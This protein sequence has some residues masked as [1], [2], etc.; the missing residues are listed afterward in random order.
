MANRSHDERLLV[1]LMN[2]VVLG[3]IYQDRSKSVRLRYDGDYLQRPDAVPLS[4]SM[5][6]TAQRHNPAVVDPWLHNLLPGRPDVLASWRRQ[7]GVADQSAF[8]LLRHVG[9]DVAGAAQFVRPER[10]DHASHP[11]PIHPLGDEDIAEWLRRLSRDAAAWEPT[12]GAGR[13]SLAGAQAKFALH[14]DSGQWGVPSGRTPT[15]HIVKPAMPNLPDQDLNEY[16]SMRT[17]RLLGLAVADSRL[18]TFGG[19]RALVTSRYDRQRRDGDWIRVHQ[20][21]MCQAL[22]VPPERKYQNQG[23]PSAAQVAALIRSVVSPQRMQEDLTRFVDAMIFNWLIVGT[24]AHAKNYS[25]LLAP[26]QVRLAPLYDLNSYLPYRV[27][28]I[29]PTLSMFIG[30]A[31]TGVDHIGLTQWRSF[32][33][34]VGVPADLVFSRIDELATHLPSAINR[35]VKDDAVQALGSPL[36]DILTDALTERAATALALVRRGSA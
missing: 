4:L 10:V 25:L 3:D 31:D 8:A 19:E 1:V 12:T 34:S 30:T 36:P 22:G 5:P 33:K 11:G 13:F 17:A 2:G 35:A 29:E 21:D 32:A 16:L 24:D 15:T 18:A 26:G 7:F 27:D 6:M 20:E 14:F 9:E 23:G 28:G